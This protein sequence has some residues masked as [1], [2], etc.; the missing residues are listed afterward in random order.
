MNEEARLLSIEGQLLAMQATI[1]ALITHHPNSGELALLVQQAV[2]RV[3]S[4]AL[5]KPVADAF[6]EGLQSGK[7]RVLPR[8]G[9]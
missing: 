7:L 3:I 5:Q 8:A 4:S 1:R 9:G 6:V 2:E